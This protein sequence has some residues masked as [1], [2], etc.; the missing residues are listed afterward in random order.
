MRRNAVAGAEKHAGHQYPVVHV[1]NIDSPCG[2]VPANERDTSTEP[3]NGVIGTIHTG[4]LFSVQS[5]PGEK[6]VE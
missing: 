4:R 3:A 5:G 6:V 1:N 2:Y